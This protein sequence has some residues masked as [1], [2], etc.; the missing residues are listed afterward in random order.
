MLLL[1]AFVSTPSL[2][3]KGDI[4]HC[5][6]FFPP[7]HHSSNS[8]ECCWVQVGRRTLAGVRD[9]W[10]TPN[11][12]WVTYGHGTCSYQLTRFKTF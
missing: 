6:S 7:F 1:V 11:V 10:Y 3:T 2:C 9:K 8:L 12:V 4:E 5:V